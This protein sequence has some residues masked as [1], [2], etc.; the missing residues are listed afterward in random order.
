MSDTVVKKLKK[1]VLYISAIFFMSLGIHLTYIYLYDG[2]ESEPIEWWTV[3]EAIIGTFPHLN[4]LVPSNDHNSYI[5]GLLY[6]SMLQ[7]STESGTFESDLVSCNL[8]NLL[9]IECVLENNLTWSD[10]TNIT[11][12]DI[13]S[14]LNIIK[15]TKVNPIMA[16]LLE[17][18]VIETS[19]DSISFKNQ[20]KDINFLHIFMQPILPE[21]VVQTLD[22]EN[23]D[24]KFSQVSGVY[25]GRFVLTNISQDETVGITKI[26]L[27]KNKNY[28]G[29]DMYINFLILNLFRD[30]AH[31]LKNKNSFNIFNDK[32]SIIWS[33][34]P[35]LSVLEYTLSQFVGSF[36]NTQTLDSDLRAYISQTLNRD[37]IVSNIGTSKVIPA[38]NPF[39]GDMNID[40]QDVNLSIEQYLEKKGYYSKKELLKSALAIRKALEEETISQEAPTLADLEELKKPVQ[41]DLTY[42]REPNNKKYSFISEDNL[43]LTGDV[44]DDIDA[45]YVN[46]YQLSWFSAGD[47][48]FYYRLLEAYDS[49][50]AWENNYAIYFEKD[51]KKEKVEE[52]TYI[53]NTDSDALQEIKSTF[54]RDSPKQ[55]EVNLETTLEEELALEELE[56]QKNSTGAVISEIK[57]SLTPTQIGKLDSR[58]YYDLDGE[59]YTVKI[60]YTQTDSAMQS[61]ALKIQDQLNTA[62]IATEISTLSLGD[63]TIGLRNESLEY[64]I[65]LI[66]INL[67]YFESN[68]FPYFHSSQVK[69]GYNFANFKKLSLDILLEELKS[70][71]L[72]TTKR[73][74]LE[75]KMLEIMAQE[76]IIKVFY[77]PKVQLLVDQN[78]KAFELPDFLPDEKHRYYPLLS[79]YLSEKRIIQSEG[80]WFIGFIKYLFSQ[81]SW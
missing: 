34:I 73:E 23:I 22:T 39:L 63:I 9:Y 12:S 15:Q 6:R 70:N 4:P 24:G 44:P 19:D 14:T 48:V 72:S 18:T 80:K 53:Y 38:Y 43:L 49:I 61:T 74:E 36:F 31:F 37:E 56:K 77:T 78:I 64:D 57:T 16:S 54:F 13:K 65:L 55:E 1:Y 26:T 71:N 8:D 32:N 40:P 7:Y 5:N 20:S 11:P 62:G 27:G 30:E 41:E 35:R 67:G 58:Y 66:G 2:A 42:I 60:V 81:F 3:S 28:F 25:S 29:N 79:A 51:G 10:G 46:D 33:T 75:N 69:N 52:F 47:N 76:N 50:A 68:I 59:V 21:S 45:V 17:E